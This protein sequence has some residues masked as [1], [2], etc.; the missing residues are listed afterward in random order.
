[1]YRLWE[2]TRKGKAHNSATAGHY[3]QVQRGYKKR[4]PGTGRP[5]LVSDY[6]FVLMASTTTVIGI[7]Y[8]TMAGAQ[9]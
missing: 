3:V 9:V 5:F 7:M 2:N 6:R 1:M 4:A 8:F